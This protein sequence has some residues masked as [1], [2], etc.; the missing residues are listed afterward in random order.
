M[1]DEVL[2]CKGMVCPLPVAKTQQKVRQMTKGKTLQ[3]IADC[4]SFPSDIKEW[5]SKT[6]HPLISI[7][8]VG[9]VTTAVIS[10]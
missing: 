4:A 6:N 9:A 5:C 3:I 2:D 10:C 7:N 1:A 8:T